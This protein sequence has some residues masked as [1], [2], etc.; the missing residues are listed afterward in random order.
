M[1]IF[2][3]TCGSR[4]KTLPITTFPVLYEVY[5]MINIQKIILNDD[6]IATLVHPTLAQGSLNKTHVVHL[7]VSD[8]VRA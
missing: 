6:L 7:K 5:C 8:L 2:I 4:S 3:V 1:T